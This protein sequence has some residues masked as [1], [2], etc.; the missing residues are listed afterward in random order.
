MALAVKT[1]NDLDAVLLGTAVQ[2]TLLKRRVCSILPA[3]RAKMPHTR[4]SVLPR[5]AGGDNTRQHPC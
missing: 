3:R 2:K 1:G 5:L 4:Q